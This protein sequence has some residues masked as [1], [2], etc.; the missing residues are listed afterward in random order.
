MR[1]IYMIFT[2]GTI[3]MKIDDVSH[4]VKPALSAK[5]IMQSL[6]N[7]ELYHELDVIEFSEIPSPS[8]TPLMMFEMSEMIK[9]LILT[10]EPIGFVIVHGT[11]TLEETAFFLDSSIDTNIP[12]VVT[13]SMK[14]SSELGFDGINNLVSSILVAKSTKSHGR[15][16][17]VVMNDQINAASEVTKSNTLSLDTFK[18]LDYG[19]IGVVDNKEVLYHRN[20]NLPRN[21]INTHHIETNVYLL[22]AYAGCDSLLIDYLLDNKAKGIVIE[23]LG[24]GNLPPAMISG[25]KRAIDMGVTIII[26]SR[27]P[28]GRALDS[29]GY[30]G[31]GK[32]LTD[33]GCIIASSLNGQKAR[34]LLMLAL[35]KSS[36]PYFLKGLFTI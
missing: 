31:G 1:K 11:D 19:P 32:Y 7:S 16:V 9:K 14:S 23:A 28:S 36:E 8:M 18:S 13:G 29:Y 5:E 15:G 27:C 22:K 10:E 26:C 2:G 24:R 20:T 17:L 25:I 34:I 30:V 33:M 35:T 6:L 3:S 12:I 4:T 21:I